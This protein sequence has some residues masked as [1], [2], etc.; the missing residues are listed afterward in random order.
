MI[1]TKK[2][3]N[4][5][6]PARAS[7]WYSAVAILEKG[8]SLIFTPIFTR[9]LTAREYGIY[10]LY[11]SWM[12]IFTVFCT[13][14]ISGNAIYRGLLKFREK[15][16]TFI[17]SSLGLITT[18][19]FTSLCLYLIFR[20]KINLLT[21]L[22]TGFCVL[23]I[24]QIFL[25]GIQNL[26]LG[27]CKFFYDYKSANIINLIF[28]LFSPLM[29]IALISL[30]KIGALGRIIAPIIVSASLAIPLL[31][32]ILKKEQRL[33]DVK[34]WK[35]LFKFLLPLLPYFIASTV[36][37]QSGR[38]I[39]GRFLGKEELGKYSVAFSVGFIISLISGAIS[40]ALHPWIIR[41]LDAKR[42][43]LTDGTSEKL[44]ALISFA[45]L[46][47]LA[48]LPEI[49]RIL[50][51]GEY[52]SAIAVVYPITICATVGFLT[53]ILSAYIG[54]FEKNYLLTLNALTVAALSLSLNLI[55]TVNYGYI[56]AAFIHLFCSIILFI[57]NY[58]S[59]NMIS[60]GD[61]FRL[62]GK[63]KHLILVSS[64][65]IILYLFRGVQISR[66]LLLLVIILFIL[67]I[68]MQCKNLMLE[69]RINE[70]QVNN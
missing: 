36:I 65:S 34:I 41:K 39:I 47:M 16:D 9:L 22:E 63:I 44:F 66:M 56:C 51:P 68:A 20:G 25:S 15:T 42:G 19:S 11:T 4:L 14:E 8:A 27:K 7:V 23:L 5:T 32:K 62:A 28:S 18:A 31:I 35:Y 60:H 48:L 52:Y 67:P 17:S 37:S 30:L 1:K 2:K 6:V 58:I 61:C 46:G 70:K 45:A 24:L 55:F 10:S 43:D 40:S 21:G 13:L 59:L 12:G 57:L 64:L 38:I 29:S 3:L 53:S 26:Y 49:F 50:A 69:K 33:F 54:Y